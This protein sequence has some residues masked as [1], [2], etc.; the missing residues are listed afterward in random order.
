MAGATEGFRSGTGVEAAVGTKAEVETT[1]DGTETG[2]NPSKERDIDES[3]SLSPTVLDVETLAGAG[4]A[5]D[6]T[7]RKKDSV[8]TG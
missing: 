1:V 4:V 8:V 6:S 7:N 2:V 5:K 3:T